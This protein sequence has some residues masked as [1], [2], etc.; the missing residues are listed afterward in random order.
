M[1]IYTNQLNTEII[2]PDSDVAPMAESD[3]ARDY[4]VYSVEALD[5]YFQDR[6]DVYVSGNL[7]IYWTTPN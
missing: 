1:T 6:E 7:F 3:P 4:L 2:Y 5:I